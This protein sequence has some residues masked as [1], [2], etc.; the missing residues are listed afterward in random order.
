MMSAMQERARYRVAV[1]GG[2]AAVALACIASAQSMPDHRLADALERRDAAAGQALL[3][4]RADVNAAQPD[5]ATPLHWAAHWNDLSTVDRLIRAGADVNRANANGITP[6]S[7]A[8]ENASGAVAKRL[9]APGT[10]TNGP[11]RTADTP[12]FTA[13]RT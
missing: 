5:G 4:G 11:H 13:P 8:C 9:L 2:T 10:Q 7:L 12:P 3:N 6:L 1:C